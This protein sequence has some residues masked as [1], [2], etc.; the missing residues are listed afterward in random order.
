MYNFRSGFSVEKREEDPKLNTLENIKSSELE[1][2]MILENYKINKPL[3]GLL[4]YRRIMPS[5]ER[6]SSKFHTVALEVSLLDH[7]FIFLDNLSALWALSS[8][9]PA[10][11]RVFFTKYHSPPSTER[12]AALKINHFSV[13]RHK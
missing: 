5:A 13:N 7:P 10:A 11:K 4:V 3:S 12:R 6:L 2:L 8:G 1:K 9:I